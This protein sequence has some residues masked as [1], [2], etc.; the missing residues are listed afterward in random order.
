M[1]LPDKAVEYVL[2]GFLAV[3]AFLLRKHT[4]GVD[5][6]LSRHA[7]KI[8]KLEDVQARNVTRKEFNDTINSVRNDMNNGHGKI[9]SRLDDLYLLLLSKADERVAK[10]QREE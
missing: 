6:R 2:G 4:N 3:L 8:D 10:S 5:E 7:E 1:E 9:Y